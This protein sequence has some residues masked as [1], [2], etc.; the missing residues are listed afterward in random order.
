[1][2]NETKKLIDHIRTTNDVEK[3]ETTISMLM[4]GWVIDDDQRSQYEPLIEISQNRLRM[5]MIIKGES[6]PLCDLDLKR[7][8]KKIE[9]S[10]M[11][12]IMESKR[13]TD[14]SMLDLMSMNCFPLC[15]NRKTS[16]K[17]GVFLCP[18]ISTV[19]LDKNVLEH[20]PDK[21]KI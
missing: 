6:H 7:D 12:S 15:S 17:V 18:K 1:M 16:T 20:G 2:D 3:L 4:F 9:M 8:K 5:L 21:F 13:Q 14:M 19:D 10:V 11:M